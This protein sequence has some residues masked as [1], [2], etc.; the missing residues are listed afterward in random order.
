MKDTKSIW[1]EFVRKYKITSITVKRRS[2]RLKFDFSVW[3]SQ[4]GKAA[5]TKEELMMA[6]YLALKEHNPELFRNNISKV[7]RAHGQEVVWNA[8]CKPDWQAFELFNAY[9]KRFVKKCHTN[10][11]TMVQVYQDIL[12]GIYGGRTRL[13]KRKHKKVDA[14]LCKKF[15]NHCHKNMLQDLK[16]LKFSESEETTIGNFWTDESEYE[17]GQVDYFNPISAK[18]H[19]EWS[20]KFEIVDWEFED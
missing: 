13:S 16:D 14:N 8:R 18:N 9:C 19:K 4:G 3:S 11:R 10:E 6:C 17:V 20:D 15:I 7:V 12:G 5:P 1:I 2:E